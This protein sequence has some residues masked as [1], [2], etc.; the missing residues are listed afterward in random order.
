MSQSE[1]TNIVAFELPEIEEAKVLLAQNKF[2][3]AESLV[4]RALE[5]AKYAVGEHSLPYAE[6]LELQ[7]R[8]K[9][10]RGSFSESAKLYQTCAQ[11]FLRNARFSDASRV[12]MLFATSVL[13]IEDSV[14]VS[15]FL[16]FSRG[17]GYSG[18]VSLNVTISQVK[19]Q[20][21]SLE[22]HK[23]R[24]K[25]SNTAM[26]GIEKEIS[27]LVS[28]LILTSL[29]SSSSL[30]CLWHLSVGRWKQT[31]YDVR[32][33]EKV[34]QEAVEAYNEAMKVSGAEERQAEL[35]RADALLGLGD[36]ARLDKQWIEADEYYKKSVELTDKYFDR[37][38][39]RVRRV[40]EREA[41]VQYHLQR[42]I[43]AEG[44]L[45]RLMDYYTEHTKP[46]EAGIWTQAQYECCAS[47]VKMMET[48]GRGSEV[49][50]LKLQVAAIN[51]IIPTPTFD[52]YAF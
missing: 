36:L 26:Q 49:S 25:G 3:K 40:I 6:L 51:T 52:P 32:R 21:L 37:D 45:R 14:D 9:F 18:D 39:Q 23:L 48:R 31:I 33:E 46:M 19:L 38:S 17:V 4:L 11:S 29:D 2:V 20:L 34:K 24:I 27:D 43:H 44:L 35:I 16:A 50:T 22:Y 8:C 30:V 47:Y 15:A 10:G 41:V 5:V 28:R 42:W 7:A 12:L 13:R 1:L